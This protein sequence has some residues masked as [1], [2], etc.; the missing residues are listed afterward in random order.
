VTGA[1]PEN[2]RSSLDADAHAEGAQLYSCRQKFNAN[3]G[4]LWTEGMGSTSHTQC[5]ERRHLW[6]VLHM[7][8]GC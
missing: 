8:F 3:A 5:S 4:T 7:R 1:A 2:P 6:H